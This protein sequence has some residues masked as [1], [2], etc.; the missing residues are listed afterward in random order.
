MRK[1]K[2]IKNCYWRL[3]KGGV[4][5]NRYTDGYSIPSI[6]RLYKEIKNNFIEKI[7]SIYMMIA[8]M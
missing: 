5:E 1:I 4:Y 6:D 2:R 8:F 3:Y 7:Q